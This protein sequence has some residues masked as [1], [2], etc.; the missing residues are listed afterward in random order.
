[1][2]N[3]FWIAYNVVLILINA[4]LTIICLKEIDLKLFISAFFLLYSLY[5]LLNRI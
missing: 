4:T 2:D 3:N 1:M 5:G